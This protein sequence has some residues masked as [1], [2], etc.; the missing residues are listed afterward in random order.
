MSGDVQLFSNAEFE[1]PL[2]VEGREFR[3]YAPTLAKQLGFRESFDMIRQLGDDEKVLVKPSGLERTPFELGVWYVTEPGFYR[4]VGQRQLGRIKDLEVRAQVERFQRWVFHEVLPAIRTKG[5][6]DVQAFTTWSYDE[7]CAQIRQQWGFDFNPATLGRALR[8]A[9]IAK[10]NGSP[11][12]K[13]KHFFHH[14]GSAWNVHPHAL[15][16]VVVKI[17]DARMAIQNAQYQ[18]PLSYRDD[19]GIAS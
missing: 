5:N 4:V 3:V 9:G 18:L 14:T 16:E 13:Y 12:S 19:R 8:D 11:R 1:L 2:D 15:R 7:V 17:S 6:Y 10:Q